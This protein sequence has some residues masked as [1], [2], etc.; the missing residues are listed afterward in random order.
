MIYEQHRA[1]HETKVSLLSYFDSLLRAKA[2]IVISA[3]DDTIG[4]YLTSILVLITYIGVYCQR[5]QR[6]RETIMLC[7]LVRSTTSCLRTQVFKIL[8]VELWDCCTQQSNFMRAF[9]CWT[10]Y[11]IEAQSE[12]ILA[13]HFRLTL[14]FISGQFVMQLSAESSCER[15]SF[16]SPQYHTYAKGCMHNLRSWRS[17]SISSALSRVRRAQTL[18]DSFFLYILI[19]SKQQNKT[20]CLSG[21]WFTC[22]TLFTSA[23]A[24]S[25]V[26]A[27]ILLCESDDENLRLLTPWATLNDFVREGLHWASTPLYLVNSQLKSS[28]ERDFSRFIG[29]G[30]E[31]LLFLS[32][33]CQHWFIMYVGKIY[34]SYRDG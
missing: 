13:L 30:L 10:L 5:V 18:C 27:L 12:Q 21:V 34:V 19:R 16:Y 9:N 29:L 4:N 6:E 22:D 31:L 33:F 23:S 3:I 25:A 1:E 17:F 8:R 26:C 11:D 32:R 2:C 7:C 15:E 20:Y 28:G 14:R 24:M